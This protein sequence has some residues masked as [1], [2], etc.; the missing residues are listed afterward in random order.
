MSL[1]N[2]IEKTDLARDALYEKVNTI[3]EELDGKKQDNLVSGTNI[4][5]INGESIVGAGNVEISGLNKNITNCITEIPQDIKLELNN[6]TLTLKAGS[7]VYV[8]NGTGVFDVKII[9]RDISSSTTGAATL[10]IITYNG[11]TSLFSGLMT[12]GTVSER[13][14]SPIRYAIYYNT[15]TNKVE[16]YDGSSWYTDCSFP[17]AIVTRSD[18]GYTS[19]DQ[20]FNGF[21]YIGK[22][23]YILPGVKLLISKGYNEDGSYKNQEYIINQVLVSNNYFGNNTIMFF[24]NYRGNRYQIYNISRANYL[25]E[26]SSVPNV[27]SGFQWYYNTTERLWYMH[28]AGETSWDQIDYTNVGEGTET[29]TKFK[30]VFRAVDYNDIKS[31]GTTITYWD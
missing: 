11:G 12:G 18:S 24:R 21:G 1:N 26:L 23:N 25:G 30:G 29:N 3:A 10:F 5:S 27:G 9:E 8:P 2:K 28:E 22:H 31:L 4:K 16:F 13:P 7:K 6:G 14:S 17:L 15:G 20:V 19:I